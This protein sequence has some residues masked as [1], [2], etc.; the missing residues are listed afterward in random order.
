MVAAARTGCKASY[1]GGPSLSAPELADLALSVGARDPVRMVAVALAESGGK[2]RA[3]CDNWPTAGTP[4]ETRD[5]GLWQ[6]NSHWFATVS[7]DEAYDPGA[8]A[9]R[10][11]RYTDGGDWSPWSR[12][13][14]GPQMATATAAVAAVR[15]E[16]A[17]GKSL[18][19][20]PTITAEG[21]PRVG[22]WTRGAAGRAA[23]GVSVVGAG[24]PAGFDMPDPLDVLTGGAG[25]VVADRLELPNPLDAVTGVADAA[26]A[27]VKLAGRAYG[28]LL[29]P[30]FW[31]KLGLLAA[32]GALV[33][34]A[35]VII[36]RETAAP[37]VANIAGDALLPTKG[38]PNE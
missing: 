22:T 37:T 31:R 11:A 27:A 17:T 26:V 14:I 38:I 19:K 20:A 9:W 13:N 4:M 3:W 7:D 18:G 16:V 8:A 28:N 30:A 15:A 2:Y 10:V 23:A 5:R 6:L 12:S 21:R 29:S 34:V 1:R 24:T 33:W 35:V 32:A 25:A 36:L